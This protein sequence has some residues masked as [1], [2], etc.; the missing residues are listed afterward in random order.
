MSQR[1]SSLGWFDDVLQDARYAVRA[2]RKSPGY[3]AIAVLT[4]AL[5]IGANTA[6]F[7]LVEGILLRPLAYSA[8][9]MLVF[10]TGTYPNGAFAAMRQQLRTTDVA[11]YADGHSFNVMG[12]GQAARLVQGRDDDRDTHPGPPLNSS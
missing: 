12:L 8:P 3:T 1:F 9:E 10:V 6:V 5:G 4:L 7:S 11:A 2:M